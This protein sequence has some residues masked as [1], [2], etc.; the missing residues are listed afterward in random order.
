MFIQDLNPQGYFTIEHWR[1]GK[2]LDTYHL[3]NGITNAGKDKLL[4]VMFHNVTQIGTWYIGLI[5]NSGYT[6]V[7]AGDTHDSHS[8]WSENTDYDESNRQEW[9]EDAAS[10]QSI[11]NTTSVDFTMS[12]SAT[13]KGIF[14]ASDNTKGGT[15]ASPTLWST[16]VFGSNATAEDDDVL[17]VTYTLNA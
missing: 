15:G 14:I 3:K 12:A 5:D 13:I 8:G 4:D 7:A 2:L 10:G 9:T 17:A 6:G 16:A 1:N 11:T